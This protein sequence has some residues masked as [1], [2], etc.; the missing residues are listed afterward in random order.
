MSLPIEK[1]YSVYGQTI[2]TRED[3]DG[4]LAES[5][6]LAS[7]RYVV[8]RDKVPPVWAQSELIFPSPSTPSGSSQIS[9]WRQGARY[10]IDFPQVSTCDLIGT[11]VICYPNKDALLEELRINFLGGLLSFWLEL[12][13]VP[14]LHASAIGSDGGAIGF[15]SHSG[16]GKSTLAAALMQ[17]GYPLLTDDILAVEYQENAWMGH[18]GYPQM[19]LWKD[20]AQYF[21]GHSDDLELVH[22]AIEKR[23]VPIGSKGFGS[24]CDKSLPLVCLYLPVREETNNVGTEIQIGKVSPRDAVIELIRYSFAAP[25]VQALG[26]QKKRMESFVQVAQQVHVRRLVFPSG[27]QSLPRVRDAILLDLERLDKHQV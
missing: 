26:L 1:C 23:C 11:S 17:A 7:F 6:G 14:V 25:F 13:G 9:I 21:L 3:F 24:F 27:L 15:L 5:A 10:R 19:R 16:N 8:A 18:P 12:Y 20:E 22:P 4:L 2:T